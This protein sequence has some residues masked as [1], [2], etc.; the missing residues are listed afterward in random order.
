M[1][2]LLFIVAVCLGRVVS[3]NPEGMT[4]RVNGYC[5]DAVIDALP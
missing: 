3:Y 1:N 5:S 2:M 4:D